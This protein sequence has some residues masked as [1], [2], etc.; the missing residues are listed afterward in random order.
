M[1]ACCLQRLL[2]TAACFLLQLHSF[3][4]G[5]H[6]EPSILSLGNT[7]RFSDTWFFDKDTGFLAS[8]DGKI[9]KTVNAGGLWE[10][11]HQMQNNPTVR[12][13]EF[14]DDHEVGIAGALN[15]VVVRS[16]D[17]GETWTNISA[18]IPDTGVARV[19]GMSHYGN[20]QFYAVGWWAS[21]T[22][23]VYKSTDAGATWQVNYIDTTLATCLVDI[24]NIDAQTL[25][26]AGGKF[27]NSKRYS[28][29]L[30]STDA[31]NSW[32]TAYTD[33]VMGG[34]IW[35]LQFLNNSLGFAAIEPYYYPDTVCILKTVDG[36]ASWSMIHIGKVA[37]SFTI[38]TQ[39]VGFINPAVGWVGGWY[40]GLFETVDSGKTWT[41][42]TPPEAYNMNRIFRVNDSTLYATTGSGVLKYVPGW[43]TEVPRRAVSYDAAHKLHPVSPN[44]AR[45][46]VT[47]TF[48]LG[49][50]TNAALEVVDIN[51]R[52]FQRI[53]SGYLAPGRYTYVW[54]G[55]DKPPGAYMVWLGTDEIPFVRKFVLQH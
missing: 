8:G 11:K 27:I 17:K 41:Y 24:I 48:E 34:R 47:I 51:G 12:S 15:G 9:I 18:N 53:M 32:T 55:S 33:S 6:W 38:G 21:T 49:H 20:N 44:P 36:G 5:Y 4:Q 23:R 1:S 39:A 31:G 22:A 35:K 14:S 28:V 7:N 30:K 19:C 25:F 29:I 54:D 45:G 43:A 13:I 52:H 26:A 3:A 37:L 50:T 46:I 2:Y 10:T 42:Q 40:Q 16:T